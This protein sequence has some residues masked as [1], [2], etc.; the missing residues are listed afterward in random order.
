[1][2]GTT[3]A[4]LA[5]AMR[6]ILFCSQDHLLKKSAYGLLR[7]D[8]HI[9]DTVEHPSDAVRSFL[10]N[11]YDAVVMDSR[12]VGLRATD[13]SA[14][15]K[16]LKADTAIFV[17]GG[18]ESGRDVFILD[19]PASPGE[20]LELV[21]RYFCIHNGSDQKGGSHDTQRNHSQSL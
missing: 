14:V 2:T 7:D 13:A 8:G 20:L 3:V 15:I 16:S 12:D 6:R 18:M 4:L 9:V 10:L 11:P 5:V 19:N 21:R 17:L 1:M